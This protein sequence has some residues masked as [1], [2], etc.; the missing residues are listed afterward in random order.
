MFYRYCMWMSVQWIQ[1]SQTV[2]YIK[3]SV[4]W[5][6]SDALSIFLYREVECLSAFVSELEL[7]TKEPVSITP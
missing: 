4:I 3:V 7:S 6:L 2:L 5:G 1:W